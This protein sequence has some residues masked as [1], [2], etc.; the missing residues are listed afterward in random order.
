M[1]HRTWSGGAPVAARLGVVKAGDEIVERGRRNRR[2]QILHEVAIVAQVVPRQ[3]HARQD[4]AA[5][6]EM[7][8]IGAAVGFASRAAAFATE[9]RQGAGVARAAQIERAAPPEG[10]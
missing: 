1:L 9:R 5:A 3:Q 2:A 7:V 4:R 8:E 10:L 6:A